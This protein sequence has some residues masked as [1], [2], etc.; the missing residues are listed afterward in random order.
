M[1]F[2]AGEN[3]WSY[4]DRLSY[5]G[6]IGIFYESTFGG[7]LA[8]LIFALIAICTIVGLITIIRWFVGHRR[9]KETPGQYWMRTGK[10]KK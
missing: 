10:M 6:G 3:L 4:L 8:W 7:V 5:R 2:I 9:G 1:K